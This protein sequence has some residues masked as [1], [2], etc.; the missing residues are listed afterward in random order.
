M[1]WLQYAK[2]FDIKRLDLKKMRMETMETTMHDR[3]A[4]TAWEL[5][6]ERRREVIGVGSRGSVAGGASTA[7]AMMAWIGGRIAGRGARAAR[8]AR[9]LPAARAMRT[10]E[11]R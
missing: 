10:A 1:R 8:L 11:P 6:A 2:S 9:T 7:G 5:E 3:I 4:V